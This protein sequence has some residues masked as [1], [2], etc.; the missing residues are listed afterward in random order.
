M[1]A[2]RESDAEWVESH[3]RGRYCRGDL[4]LVRGGF[5]VGARRYPVRLRDRFGSVIDAASAAEHPDPKQIVSQ[6]RDFYK[7]VLAPHAD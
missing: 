7:R 5:D 4:D 2:I 6:R 3:L 1:L